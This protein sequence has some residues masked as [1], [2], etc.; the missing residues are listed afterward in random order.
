MFSF[1]SKFFS[2]IYS[3]LNYYVD[4][5]TAITKDSQ[6]K[7]LRPVLKHDKWS[8]YHWDITIGK[9]LVEGEFGIDVF[10]AELNGKVVAVKSCRSDNLKDMDKFMREADLKQYDHPNVVR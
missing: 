5:G 6:V 7:I 1:E 10:Q 4:T 8:L 2:T 3:L 9:K